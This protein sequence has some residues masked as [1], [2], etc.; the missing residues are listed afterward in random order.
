MKLDIVVP[1]YNEQEVLPETAAR[2]LALLD[3]MLAEGDVDEGSQVI[4]VDDGSRDA[5]WALISE[6]AASD[7]RVVGVKLSRNRGHQAALMAGLSVARG[8]AVVSIDADL[9]DDLEAIVAMV[10]AHAAGADVVYGV[11]RARQTDSVFKRSTAQGYY[12]LLAAFGV[13]IVYNHADFRLLSRRALACLGS[14]TEVNLFLRGIVPQLGFRTSV[15]QFDRSARFAGESKYPLRKMLALA[16]DGITSFSA[17]PLRFVAGLGIVVFL[18]SIGM[19]AWVLWIRLMTD[20]SVPG[21][22]STVI[23]MYFLGGVQLLSIGLTGEYVAKTYMETK[24][25]PRFFIEEIAGQA[26][27]HD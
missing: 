13:D 16:I 24:R 14:Y 7:A 8:D 4:F 19:A 10:R 9:Q 27:V 22:A 20:D 26:A 15:V 11:R 6:R 1:C 23:P 12:R 21:W 17:T 5:T 2:L 3:R 18:G 25:R